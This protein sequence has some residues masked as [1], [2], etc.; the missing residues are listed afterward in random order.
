AGSMGVRR[1][2]VVVEDLNL[3]AAAQADPAVR[4]FDNPE[5]DVQFEVPELLLG[6]K[7]GRGRRVAE[8]AVLDCPLHFDV[9]VQPLPSGSVLAIKKIDRSS[10]LPRAVVAV[11]DLWRADA[12]PFESRPGL[13][14]VLK[15]AVQLAPGKAGAIDHLPG[16]GPAGARR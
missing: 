13:P 6:D 5:I 12:G 7:V 4:M 9:G 2:A 15:K 1:L 8:H 14:L 16:R 11:G 3:V 10:F